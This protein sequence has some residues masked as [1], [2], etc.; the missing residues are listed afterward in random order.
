MLTPTGSSGQCPSADD[1]A[2]LSFLSPRPPSLLLS[3]Y[4]RVSALLLSSFSKLCA[5]NCTI[6]SVFS[7]DRGS[8][9]PMVSL[10]TESLPHAHRSNNRYTSQLGLLSFSWGCPCPHNSVLGNPNTCCL[11]KLPTEDLSL[12]VKPNQEASPTWAD[13]HPRTSLSCLFLILLP[14]TVLVWQRSE[15]ATAALNLAP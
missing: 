3:L 12:P 15:A 10:A 14:I 2:T 8:A 1:E 13:L 9:P 5:D 6:I 4:P 11:L 7:Q